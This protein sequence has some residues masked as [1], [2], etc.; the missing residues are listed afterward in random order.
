ME[1]TQDLL[2]FS[3]FSITLQS[4][5]GSSVQPYLALEIL[6]SLNNFELYKIS[7]FL[8]LGRNLSKFLGR[9]LIKKSFRPDGNS[10]NIS[11]GALTGSFIYVREEQ[12]KSFL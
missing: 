10:W 4:H 9:K 12:K 6:E 11:L 2:V 8:F 5:S 1:R 3:L 7:Y